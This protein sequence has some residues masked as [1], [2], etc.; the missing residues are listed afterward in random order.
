MENI[1]D[2]FFDPSKRPWY[3]NGGTR[4]PHPAVKSKRTGRRIARLWP[5]EDSHDDRI[6]NQVQYMYLHIIFMYKI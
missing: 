5:D 6:T 4:R 1:V 3:M 2:K